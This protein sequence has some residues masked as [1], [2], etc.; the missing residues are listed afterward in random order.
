MTKQQLKAQASQDQAIANLLKFAINGKKEL[1]LFGKAGTGKTYSAYK[2]A[3][4]IASAICPYGVI[5]GAAI[6]NSAKNILKKTIPQSYTLASFLMLK[7]HIDDEGNVSFIPTKGYNKDDEC[8]EEPPIT[9]ADIIIIDECSQISKEIYDII[10]LYKKKDAIVIY[11]GDWR[12]TPPP[13]GSEESPSFNIEHYEILDTPFRY[14]GGIQKFNDA[15]GDMITDNTY[16]DT[17]DLINKMQE[18]CSDFIVYTDDKKFEDT[19]LNHLRN[20]IDCIYVCYRN[21]TAGTKAIDFKKELSTSKSDLVVGDLIRMSKTYYPPRGKEGKFEQSPIASEV[22]FVYKIE[23]G[24]IKLGFKTKSGKYELYNNYYNSNYQHTLEFKTYNLTLKNKQGELFYM[25]LLH[26]FSKPLHKATLQRLE[27]LAKTSK[28]SK[29]WLN[30]FFM[31]ELFGEYK[32]AYAVNTYV[33]QGKTYE[34]IFVNAI[35]IFS[36]KPT[37]LKQKYQSLYTACTRAKKRIHLL[38]KKR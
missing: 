11:L 20:N 37:T 17:R 38:I 34:E 26:S 16:N 36:V 5:C 12:Q 6:S 2:L 13:D 27:F 19:Y 33:V 24:I 9:E 21:K 7:R 10:N 29:A 14:E 30:Y 23:E 8:T 4:A 32:Y 28:S 3:K 15:I 31:K 25:P 18:E 35:D 1:G 22:Y